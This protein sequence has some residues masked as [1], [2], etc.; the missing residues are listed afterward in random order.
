MK[1]GLISRLWSWMWRPS[2][3]AAATL[4]ILGGTLGVIAT[5]GFVGFVEYSNTEEFCVGCHEMEGVYEEFKTSVHA[6]NGSGVGAICSDCH[7]PKTWVEKMVAKVG[8]TKELYHKVLGTISTPE[9]FEAHRLQMARSTWDKMLASDS[10]ECRNC[11]SWDRM[12]SDK[13]RDK[14]RPRHMKARQRGETCIGCHK[15]IAHK[16]PD[17]EP[18]IAAAREALEVSKDKSTDKVTVLYPAQ[19]ATLYRDDARSGKMG[20][21]LVATPL[22]VLER[23]DDMVRVRV[24]GWREP[25]KKNA[26]FAD[27]GRRVYRAGLRKSALSA[28]QVEGTNAG[29]GWVSVSVEGWV[30]NQGMV[31]DRASIWAFAETLYELQCSQ[32]HMAYPAEWFGIDQWPDLLKAMKPMVDLSK[33]DNRL[34]QIYLQSHAPLEGPHDGTIRQADA[35][36]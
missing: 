33:D 27:V 7:V 3:L 23:A 24:E 4:L 13:Q 9:K 18:A 31:K 12:I 6:A 11:H 20:T 30:K 35:G 22:A 36:S 8:A 19:S 29:G 1:R 25:G 16:K 10:R 14:A 21:I 34:L 28:I 2:R 32:C 5:G 26:I 15:G 17:I